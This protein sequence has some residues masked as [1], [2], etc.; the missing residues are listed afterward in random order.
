MDEAKKIYR[1][2]MEQFVAEASA[3]PTSFELREKHNELVADL[4]V[5]TPGIN[6]LQLESELRAV[7]DLFASNN[8]LQRQMSLLQSALGNSLF[9]ETKKDLRTLAASLSCDK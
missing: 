1:E 8:K 2:K 5:T 9:E 6:S 7:F 3:P 4:K